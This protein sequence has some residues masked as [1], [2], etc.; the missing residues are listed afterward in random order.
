MYLSH[1]FCID[2]SGTLL[3]VPHI[4]IL[5]DD[6]NTAYEDIV[7]HLD[8]FTDTVLPMKSTSLFPEK[9]FFGIVSTYMH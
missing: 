5:K 2:L 1:N 6:S 4:L 3:M 7:K 9:E 8:I